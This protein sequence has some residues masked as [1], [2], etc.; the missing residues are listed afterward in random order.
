[1]EKECTHGTVTPELPMPSAGSHRSSFWANFSVCW[2]SQIPGVGL[3]SVGE[4]WI[5]IWKSYINGE[6]NSALTNHEAVSEE[7]GPGSY[8]GTALSE[9]TVVLETQGEKLAYRRILF[10]RGNLCA[11]THAH[12]HTID[13]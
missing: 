8:M 10:F 12:T 5:S 3:F 1:M 13:R 2:Y 11:R 6:K 4:H 7:R 9:T